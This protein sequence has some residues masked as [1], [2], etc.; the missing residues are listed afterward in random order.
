M[1]WHHVKG[2]ARCRAAA[3]TLPTCCVDWAAILIGMPR[4]PLPEI[5]VPAWLRGLPK[6]ELHL[7]LEGTIEP[8]TLVSLSRRHD[9]RPLDLAAA[10]KL[11]TY[12]NFLGFLQAFKAV[13]ERLRTPDDYE[14]ITYNMVRALA[15][16]GVLHAE[17]YI[18]FG[19]IYFWKKEEVEP[20]VEAI[21]RGRI[22]GE[23]EFGTTI[24][25]LID[26]VR[27]FG[28]EE[29]TR[30]FRKA[31]ELRHQYPSI[32]GIGIGGDEARGPAHLF[33]EHYAEAAAAGLRLT[34]HAGESGGAVDGPA[35]IWSAINIG[36]ERLGHVLAAQHDPQLLEVLAERQIPIEINVTSNIR[37]GCCP[38]FDEHPLRQYFD[39]GLMVTINSDDPPMF[40]ANLLDEYILVQERYG[41]SLDQMRELAANGV[42][43]SFLPATRKLQLLRQVELYG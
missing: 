10:R 5:D 37:T 38:S 33:K 25:W 29:A 27:N 39:A 41:F 13:T 11:Y 7:H 6:V 1:D 23:Q 16:Q 4:K 8:Q 43:A 24:Y 21:E 15:Q 14:L 34:A 35:S 3:D 12:E 9:A 36:A 40:G 2:K 32:I 26:A 30:V 42:E 17:V 31:A 20:Y 18:S 19:I 22:R 28:P